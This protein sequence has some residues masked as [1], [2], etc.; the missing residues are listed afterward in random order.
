MGR[1]PERAVSRDA[2]QNPEAKKRRARAPS[3][4]LTMPTETSG[5]PVSG[6]GDRGRA[7]DGLLAVVTAAVGH[8]ASPTPRSDWTGTD[9]GPAAW[10][11]C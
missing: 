4:P 7:V 1:D 6:T 10:T 5:A 8:P 11:G 9:P 2:L 3:S